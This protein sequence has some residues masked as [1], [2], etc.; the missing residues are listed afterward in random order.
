MKPE[1]ASIHK[2]A[3]D[4]QIS[5][6]LKRRLPYAP[7]QPWFVRTIMNRL[8][9]RIIRIAATIERILYIIGIISS[10]TVAA[11]ITRHAFEAG[12]ISINNSMTLIGMLA[13]MG[14]LLYALISPLAIRRYD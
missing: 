2:S 8:P 3:D 9:G 12:Q 1:N 13:L 5:D 6:L 11:V 10:A 14:L 4:R 7:P